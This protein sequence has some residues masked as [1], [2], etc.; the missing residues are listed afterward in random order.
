MAQRDCPC[1]PSDQVILFLP[2]FGGVSFSF[3]SSLAKSADGKFLAP[4]PVEQAPAL[5]GGA[6]EGIQFIFDGETLPDYFDPTLPQVYVYPVEGLQALD[7]SI[8]AGVESLGKMIDAE[9]VPPGESIFVYPLIPASQVFARANHVSPICEWLGIQFHHLLCAG[10]F[11]DPGTARVLYFPG[12]DAR[13]QILRLGVLASH[14]ACHSTCTCFHVR[15]GICKVL[16]R[17]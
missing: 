3:D 4:V 17:L 16:A 7:P 10:C 8:A 12:N 5:G 2:A 15:R 14:N 1:R 13:P 6:P 9:Q 11:A